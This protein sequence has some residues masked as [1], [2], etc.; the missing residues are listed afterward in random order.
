MKLLLFFCLT[1]CYNINS[2]V[3][4]TFNKIETEFGEDYQWLADK[5]CAYDS[6]IEYDYGDTFCTLGFDK[7]DGVSQCKYVG[8][9]E[10][11]KE[12][13]KWINLMK[14]RGYVES[15]ELTWRDYSTGVEHR[16][17]LYH[18]AKRVSYFKYFF[19]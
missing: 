6:C 12:A 4:W 2:Q 15:G 3:G 13:N 10:S 1:I 17:K 9:Y 11:I 19:Q 7:I 18:D 8:W 14:E 16:V 5:D